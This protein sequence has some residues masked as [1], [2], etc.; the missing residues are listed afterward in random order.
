MQATSSG[1]S[2]AVGGVLKDVFASF[3]SS[4]VLGEALV[5]PSSGYGL[6]FTLEMLLLFATL[7]AMAPLSRKNVRPLSQ[8]LQFG[9]A[10]LPN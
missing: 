8:P 3:A 2:M 4:G 6:V 9:L 1:L 7:V 5:N 10:E